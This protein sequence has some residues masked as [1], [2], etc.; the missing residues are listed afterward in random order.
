MKDEALLQYLKTVCAGKKHLRSG[1]S[2]Q[3]ALH[4]SEKELR[5]RIHCLR[6]RGA[7]IAATRQG[8]FYA[9][10]AGELYATI[11]QM[12]KLRIG[13]DAAIRGLET[14]YEI[15]D[16]PTGGG[17]RWFE[18]YTRTKAPKKVICIT[19]SFTIPQPYSFRYSFRNTDYH[20][21]CLSTCL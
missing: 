16:L 13:I 19:F 7:P 5:R 14:A 2:L 18:L 4:L 8:Y 17:I 20:L 21:P 11:R 3:S 12:E 10:T 9:E 6:C 15:H 1:R